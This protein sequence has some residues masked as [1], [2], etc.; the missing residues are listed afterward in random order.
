MD[1][2]IEDSQTRPFGCV[3]DSGHPNGPIR[4]TPACHMTLGSCECNVLRA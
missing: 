1:L 4:G 3:E 2:A